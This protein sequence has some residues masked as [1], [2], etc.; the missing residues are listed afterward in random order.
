M[1]GQFQ[2]VVNSHWALGERGFTRAEGAER[3]IEFSAPPE[4]NGEP[5]FWTPEQFLLAAVASCFITTFQAIAG[6]SKFEPLALDITVHGHLS[7]SQGGYDFTQIVLRPV[8]TIR[9]ESQ[10]T[11]ASRLLAKT[12]HACLVARAL[13]CEIRMEAE[14]ALPQSQMVET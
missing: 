11:L 14:I 8:L 6:F 2:Y 3:A 9:D 12:E 10:R 7:K 4:F 5:G 13:K 1:S